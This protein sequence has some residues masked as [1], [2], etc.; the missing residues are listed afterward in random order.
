[1]V[2]NSHLGLGLGLAALVVH[3][4]SGSEVVVDTAAGLDILVLVDRSNN[5]YLA[6]TFLAGMGC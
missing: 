4:N 3:N 6:Q 5:L 1:V 2:D